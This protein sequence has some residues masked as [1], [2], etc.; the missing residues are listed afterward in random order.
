MEDC[1]WVLFPILSKVL[2]HPWIFVSVRVLKPIPQGYE[3]RP[4]PHQTQVS[5]FMCVS[6]SLT[7]RRF[8]EE[9]RC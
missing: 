2:E 7:L 4:V 3:R 5:L 8:A 9:E 1:T 6:S